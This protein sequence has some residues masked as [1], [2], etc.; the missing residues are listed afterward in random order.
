MVRQFKADAGYESVDLLKYGR[1]HLHAAEILFLQDHHCLDSAAHLGHL[2]IELL[3]KAAL[4]H[5]SGSFPAEHD[6]SALLQE[7]ATAG[8]P[9]TL[10]ED[11]RV[12]LGAIS[13]F[14]ECRYPNPDNPIEIGTK[15]LEM[16][17]Q[18]WDTLLDQ[19]PL[20]LRAAFLEADQ[21]TKGGRTLF[22]N[23]PPSEPGAT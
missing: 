3:L 4:L 17:Q 1:G 6:L 20:E 2:A 11:Q 12:L 13:P 9:F 16:I 23:T 18:L 19:I 7:A 10:S 14:E 15:D 8:L 21:I 22:V 5:K